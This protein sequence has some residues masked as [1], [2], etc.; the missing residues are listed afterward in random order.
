[1]KR[2]AECEYARMLFFVV[3]PFSSGNKHI[4]FGI[5]K[6]Y[7]LESVRERENTNNI[8]P[9]P[10]AYETIEKKKK[11]TENSYGRDNVYSF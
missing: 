10:E 3:I 9:T 5:K 7:L 4:F 1:M 8:I 11:I 6:V 2:K